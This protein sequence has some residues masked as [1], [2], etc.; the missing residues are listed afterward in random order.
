M[1][2][3]GPGLGN[4][5][6]HPHNRLQAGHLQLDAAVGAGAAAVVG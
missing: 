5:L 1:S 6:W 4:N 3:I 2:R